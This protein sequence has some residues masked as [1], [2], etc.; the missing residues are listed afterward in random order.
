MYK[1]VRRMLQKDPAAGKAK[2]RNKS[3]SNS[4]NAMRCDKELWRGREAYR[5]SN[6]LVQLIALLGGGHIAEFRFTGAGGESTLNPLWTPPWQTMEPYRYREQVHARSYGSTLEG[7]LL[8]GLVGHNLCLDYFG[9]PSPAEAAQGLSQHGEAPSLRWRRAG[10]AASGARVKIG[11]SVR[12]PAAGLRFQR[13]IALRKGQPVAYFTETVQN[14]RRAD[15]FFHWTEHVTIGPPFLSKRSSMVFLPGARG[16]TFP[17]GYS[18]GKSLL[19]NEKR[20]RWPKA[21]ARQ[22][23]EVNLEKVLIRK[24]CGFVASVLV[25]PQR[26]WGYV[27]AL[28]VEHR[29]LLGYGFRRKDFPWIALWEENRAIRAAPW[30]GRT[31][32]RGLEFGTTPIPSTRRDTFRRGSLYGTETFACIP[33]RGHQ[34]VKYL[35]F[36]AQAPAAVRRISDIQFSGNE[37]VVMGHAGDAVISI[38]AESSW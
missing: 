37:I 17:S 29:L 18:D 31:E 5:L 2:M 1:L 16:I 15:H 33:A 7:K 9:A 14:E 21:P 10:Q 30:K 32:T 4:F 22:G 6:G 34:T 28:N 38:P 13:E 25:D 27:C 3:G 26:E 11:L 36:L 19:A 20:F 35:A 12:L 23:G 24:G 8:S